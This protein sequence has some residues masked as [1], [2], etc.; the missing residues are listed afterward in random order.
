MHLYFAY[1]SNLNEAQMHDRCPGAEL[2]GVATLENYRLA[3]TIY[4]PTRM[5]GCADIVT[6]DGEAV[7][8]LLYRL[9]DTDAALMDDFEG[10]PVHY[11]RVDVRVVSKGVLVQAYTYEVV[12]KVEGL[13][14]SVQ[15]LGLITDAAEKYDFPKKY[16]T[17]LRSFGVSE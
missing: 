10:H 12:H 14:P 7:Y 15:Y 9:S 11:K 3:F 17:H 6:C 5:C 8:G 13:R 4:S 2:V 1:G 16:Q